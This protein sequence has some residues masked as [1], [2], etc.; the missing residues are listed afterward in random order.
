MRI[1]RRGFRGAIDSTA[2]E[3]ELGA[4]LMAAI[5]QRGRTARVRFTDPDVV[6]LVETLRDEVG[7][8]IIPRAVRLAYPFVRAR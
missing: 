4:R 3:R 7:I 1:A 6:V 5:E 8:G 2:G